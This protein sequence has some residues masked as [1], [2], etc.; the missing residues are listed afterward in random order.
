MQTLFTVTLLGLK[1]LKIDNYLFFA[2][3][4][5]VMEAVAKSLEGFLYAHY[6]TGLRLFMYARYRTPG[7]SRINFLKNEASVTI[8]TFSRPTRLDERLL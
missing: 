5:Y 1:G 3:I 4:L 8:P 6:R 7:V 2:R